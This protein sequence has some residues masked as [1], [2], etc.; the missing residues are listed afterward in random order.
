V[1]SLCKL[2][3]FNSSAT[4]GPDQQICSHSE[5]WEVPCCLVP[6]QSLSPS[7]W[8]FIVLACSTH[9]VAVNFF[10]LLCVVVWLCGFLDSTLTLMSYSMAVDS[11]VI[12]CNWFDLTNSF[13]QTVLGSSLY[14]LFAPTSG[15]LNQTLSNCQGNPSSDS[16]KFMLY[17]SMVQDQLVVS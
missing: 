14:I 9:A 12:S 11:V 17:L 1:F 8:N 6:S 7:S 4:A 16:R 5:G 3:D 2:L 15:C 10:L 13:H